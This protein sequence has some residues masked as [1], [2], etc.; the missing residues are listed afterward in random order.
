MVTI[1]AYSFKTPPNLREDI[2]YDQWKKEIQLWKTFTDLPDA[3]QGPAICLALT[4]KAREA[5]LELDI[6]AI[7][8][9]DGV[10]SLLERLDKLYLRDRDQTI[11]AAYE[12]FEK[13]VRPLDMGII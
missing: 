3:K 5:V 12:K 8:S 13:F 1:M 10:K 7:S 9:E 2:S 4:G 11:Y 6:E